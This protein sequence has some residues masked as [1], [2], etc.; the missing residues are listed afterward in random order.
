MC[1]YLLIALSSLAGAT[2]KERFDA[3]ASTSPELHRM[4]ENKNCGPAGVASGAKNASNEIIIMATDRGFG[5]FRFQRVDSVCR[6]GRR[7]RSL[8]RA[9]GMLV[10]KSRKPA[11]RVFPNIPYNEKFEGSSSL[12]APPTR[13]PGVTRLAVRGDERQTRGAP[14]HGFSVTWPR[15]AC[16]SARPIFPALRTCAKLGVA[17]SAADTGE[18]ESRA[19]YCTSRSTP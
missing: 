17:G 15:H 14:D 6:N 9:R 4:A 3:N 8:R 5:G 7:T 12:L 10:A 18:L 11:D 19:T 1:L 16:Q 2:S 13:R